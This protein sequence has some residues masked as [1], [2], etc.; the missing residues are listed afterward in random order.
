MRLDRVGEDT[1]I[2]SPKSSKRF[3]VK[4]REAVDSTEKALS[5]AGHSSFILLV[6]A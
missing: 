3:G 1:Y 4:K 5:T 6:V 2:N